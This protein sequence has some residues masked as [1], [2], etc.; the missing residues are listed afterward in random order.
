[1]KDAA[2]FGRFT[3]S[4]LTGL[5]FLFLATLSHIRAYSKE[6][7]DP[8][9]RT[10]LEVFQ[11]E[12]SLLAAEV[13]QRSGDGLGESLFVTVR[14]SDTSWVARNTI[15]EALKKLNYSVFLLS[16]AGEARGAAIDLG[17]VEMRVR[18][19]DAF[20]ESFLGTRKTERTISTTISANVRN[21]QNEVLF[22]G[23][24]SKAYKDTVNVSQVPELE[25]PSIFFTHGELRGTEFLEEVLEP[26]IIVGA[27][28]VV[29][30]LFFTVRS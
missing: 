5:I 9:I 24:I 21:A 15:V 14:S 2:L 22:A 27:S 4:T 12:L 11:T 29:V 28:A 20:R 7:G 3:H 30:Y 16:S 25:S 18:Y 13:V 19:G 23:A 17:I 26:I 6:Q 8:P 10:N 1:M